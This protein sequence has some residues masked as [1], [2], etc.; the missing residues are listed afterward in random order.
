MVK[1]K[2]EWVSFDITTRTMVVPS[3][4]ESGREKQRYI[5]KEDKIPEVELNARRVEEDKTSEKVYDQ[6]R[7]AQIF[8]ITPRE[9]LT[10]TDLTDLTRRGSL[11]KG[12]QIRDHIDDI[13]QV[14]RSAGVR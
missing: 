1:I 9:A 2:R 13:Q 5:D 3:L 7:P 8:H 10:T 6:R 12:F 4:R 11:K 14:A